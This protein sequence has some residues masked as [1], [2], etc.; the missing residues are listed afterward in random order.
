M[1]N[2]FTDNEDIIFQFENLDLE[3]I[4]AITEDNY[5]Q[6][7][8]FNYAPVNYADAMENYR[9]ILEIA[10]DIAGNFIAPRATGVDEDGK[11][12]IKFYHLG[13]EQVILKKVFLRGG[14]YSEDLDQED[15]TTYTVGLGYTQ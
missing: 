14:I 5:S 11:K 10:G 4:V 12:R 8:E 2:F 9:I 3:E 1:P 13:L 7:E 15:K 6:A